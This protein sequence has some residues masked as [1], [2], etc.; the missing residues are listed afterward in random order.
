MRVSFPGDDNRGA[1]NTLPAAAC[2][3]ALGEIGTGCLRR[4]RLPLWLGDIIK[5][6]RQY[7]PAGRVT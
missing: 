5:L 7:H 2:H 1:S 6:G 4:F 3:K